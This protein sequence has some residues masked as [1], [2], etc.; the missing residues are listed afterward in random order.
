MSMT[1]DQFK[2]ALSN[3]ISI[4]QLPAIPI[5]GAMEEVKTAMVIDLALQN[6]AKH[7]LHLPPGN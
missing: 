3:L 6:V 2:D 1:P 7:R 5:I 4:A